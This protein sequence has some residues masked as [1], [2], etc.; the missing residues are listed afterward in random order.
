MKHLRRRSRVA[1]TAMALACSAASGV[2]LLPI[3]DN[4]LRA[5]TIRSDRSDSLYTSLG[6]DPKYAAVGALVWGVNDGIRAS[7]VLISP[8]FV[9]SAAHTTDT[10]DPRTFKLGGAT[11]DSSTISVQDQYHFANPNWVPSALQAGNDVGLLKLSSAI[12]TVVPA[13]RFFFP[14]NDNTEI[15]TLTSL[16]ART[17]TSVGYGQSGTGLTGAPMDGAVGPGQSATGTKRGVQNSIDEYGSFYSGY[18]S[19]IFLADFDTPLG[20]GTNSFG[21]STPTNLEGMVAPGDSGGGTFV[22]IN[23]RTYLI[24]VHSF[25][26]SLDGNTNASYN[27]VFG[28]TRVSQFNQFIDNSIVHYWNSDSNG[29]FGIASGW[30]LGTG[31]NAANINP[32]TD[33]IAGFNR[34]S[35]YTLTFAGNVNNH[36]LLA[37]AGDVTLDLAGNTY[38]LTS[39]MG[40]GAMVVARYNAESASVTFASGTVNTRDVLIGQMAGSAGRITVGNGATMN[41]TGDLYVGGSFFGAGG[42]GTLAVASSNSS[43]N[44]SGRLKVHSNGT[45]NFNAGSLSVGTL[46]LSSNARVNVAAGGNK[47]LRTKA[48]AIATNGKIDLTDNDMIVT[49][50]SISLVKNFIASGYANGA[51]NGTGII[52]SNAAADAR[53]G[54]GQSNTLGINTFDGVPVTGANVLVKYT[55]AGDANL[56]GMVNQSDLGLFALGWNSAGLW[57]S[58]DFNYDGLINVA[59]FKLLASNWLKGVTAPL[60]EPVSLAAVM[61]SMGLDVGDLSA[62]PEPTALGVLGAV[63]ALSACR[64]R[65]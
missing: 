35:A 59:D 60:S 56:D 15:A 57:T 44:V 20:G 26:G 21:S 19:N 32:V 7:A 38:T 50:Q 63:F 14:L 10:S 47:V 2:G 29:S 52:S 64:R 17:G 65:R 36:Q 43:V 53:F 23:G 54:Y 27:D 28:M 37:R 30:T 5:G 61:A 13:S 6:T 1:A 62:V 34:A 33:D 40:E 41:V 45:V 39:T 42:A 18:S 46:D 16:S 24:G 3:F 51:W 11:I 12:T 8:K 55:Y 25:I 31:I 9:L 58:G 4:Q 22:D 48:L 49:D